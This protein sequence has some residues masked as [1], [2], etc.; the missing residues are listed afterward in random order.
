MMLKANLVSTNTQLR[1]FLRLHNRDTA[2]ARWTC[3]L[4]DYC[5][6]RMYDTPKNPIVNSMIIRKP[7]SYWSGLAHILKSKKKVEKYS[8]NTA[9]L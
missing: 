6:T 4:A 2:W 3:K 9:K 1:H 8:H 5:Y 7:K